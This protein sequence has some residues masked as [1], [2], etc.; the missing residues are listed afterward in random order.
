MRNVAKEVSYVEKVKRVSEEERE[1][2]RASLDE[3]AV[4][5][6]SKHPDLTFIDI[7]RFLH[8]MVDAT[9]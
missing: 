1:V 8:E 6:H 7:R 5:I 3:I 2:V 9:L 4:S